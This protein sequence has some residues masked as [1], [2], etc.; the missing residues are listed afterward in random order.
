MTKKARDRIAAGLREAIEIVSGRADPSTYRVHVPAEFDIAAM[1][2]KLG[3]S[4]AAFA[5]KFGFNV[6]RIRDWEQGRSMPDGAMRAYLKVI[7]KNPKAV[8]EALDAA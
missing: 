3:L 7:Q 4:Q 1:R 2:K 5:K 6:A 8:I